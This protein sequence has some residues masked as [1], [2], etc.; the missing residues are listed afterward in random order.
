MA[1]PY[2]DMNP[3]A[4]ILREANDILLELQM[5]GKVF[6]QQLKVAKQF[7]QYLQDINEQSCCPTPTELVQNVSNLQTRTSQ[8]ERL[9]AILLTTTDTDAK[10][11]KPIPNH[12]IR[13]AK[14]L[15]G[16]IA[17]R[18]NELQD[19]AESTSEVIA[20]VSNIQNSRHSRIR[21]RS[22]VA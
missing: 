16:K 4:T 7:S 2:L 18:Q 13:K 5:M 15:V 9:H 22:P 8:D 21:L 10:F 17:D 20:Q 3:E 11:G 19:L 6:L 12:T 1:R 14:H